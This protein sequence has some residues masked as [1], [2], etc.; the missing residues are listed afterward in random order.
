MISV[1]GAGRP[2]TCTG[3]IALVRGVM[4]LSMVS[5]DRRRTARRRRRGSC[6]PRTGGGEP[7]CAAVEGAEVELALEP[8]ARGA[9]RRR[10]RSRRRR[11]RRRCRS[12]PAVA[13]RGGDER[14]AVPSQHL[15]PGAIVGGAVGGDVVPELQ[16][17]PARRCGRRGRW[18]ARAGEV[19]S[20]PRGRAWRTCREVGPPQAVARG[21][22]RRP[23]EGRAPRPLV[24]RPEV[25]EA[26]VARPR[27]RRGRPRRAARGGEGEA[28]AAVVVALRLPGGIGGGDPEEVAAAGRRGRS[29]PGEWAVTAAA[30]TTRPRTSATS[31]R[32]RLVGIPGDDG[33]AVAERGRRARC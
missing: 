28:G 9:R 1:M 10:R 19:A 17:Q 3:M 8:S 5:T 16:A 6:P 18:A 23:G 29:R 22:R 11:R 27:S 12:M 20:G 2:K 14:P 24:E 32:R 7:G 13:A 30:S 33:L 21:G 25:E 26:A 31:A 15:D 4:A